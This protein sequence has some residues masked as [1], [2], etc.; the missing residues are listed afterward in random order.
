MGRP[1][2]KPAPER[3]QKVAARAGL[4]SRRA[5]ERL[6][7]DGRVRI[8]DAVATAGDTVGSGDRVVVEDTHYRVTN[9]SGSK[10]RAL[11][12]H[13][14]EG[15]LTTRDDPEGRPTV[16]DRLPHLSQGR[17]V[18]VGRLDYNTSG[19]LLLTTDGELAN[20]MMHPSG[21][22]DREYACRVHG[23]VT[24]EMLER[25]RE[26]VKLEDGPAR[27]TDIVPGEGGAANR[28]YFVA[29]MEGRYREVRR[30]WESQ[31]VS[32]NRLKRV[33]YGAVFL[34]EDLKPGR[35]VELQPSDIRTL[36]EDV[37]LPAETTTLTLR[38]VKPSAG[39]A[40]RG[41][42]K[43]RKKKPRARAQRRKGQ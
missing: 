29:L 9:V 7:G 23:E 12:Y 1:D 14:P 28:W 34:P 3:L 17:W 19:L 32:V 42:G 43:A 20:A 36:R 37:G 30:L 2:A 31:G 16:F 27:F 26:G 11:I 5:F 25:L 4:A 41:G 22:V 24:D 18:A 35:W 21:N 6:I 15:E 39:K 10:A 40:S 13:K 8:N 33:R 38:P